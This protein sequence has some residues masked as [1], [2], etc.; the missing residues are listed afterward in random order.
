[1]AKTK[2]KLL[3]EVECHLRLSP[4]PSENRDENLSNGE[5]YY[6]SLHICALLLNKLNLSEFKV[7]RHATLSSKVDTLTNYIHAEKQ[8]DI[9]IV[10]P[11]T[12]NDGN[13]VDALRAHWRGLIILPK[14]K[15]ALVIDSLPAQPNDK[16]HNEIVALYKKSINESFPD[17]EVIFCNLD[18]QKDESYNNA[19]YMVTNLLAVAPEAHKIKKAGVLLSIEHGDMNSLRREYN[20]F[21]KDYNAARDR[22]KNPVSQSQEKSEDKQN[23]VRESEAKSENEIFTHSR[24][25]ARSRQGNHSQE[26]KSN[27]KEF[28]QESESSSGDQNLRSN[29]APIKRPQKPESNAKPNPGKADRI[30]PRAAFGEKVIVDRA[31]QKKSICIIL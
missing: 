12:D 18:Q 9:P 21:F 26:S 23:S 13:E 20:L 30:T 5:L 14:E 2:I 25:L 15:R 27:L 10:I 17:V 19:V 11:V 29:K 8:S 1:M 16:A 6:D 24:L 31:N 7:Y 22:Y 3:K 28:S 4:I